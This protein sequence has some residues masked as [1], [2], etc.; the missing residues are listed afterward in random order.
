MKI[1]IMTFWWSEDNYGQILQCY[2]LQKYLRDTG[3]DAY[4]IRYDPRKDYIKNPLTARFLKALN[5]IKL[6]NFIRHKLR[7]Y[8][9]AKEQ[10]ACP[11]YFSQF[12]NRYLVQSEKIYTSYNQLKTDPPTADMYIVGSDQVWNFYTSKLQKVINTV[13]A[14]FLDF[15]GKNIKRVSYAASWGNFFI[16]KNFREEIQPLL[17][18]FDY[19]SV[20]EKSG[21]A[22]CEDCHAQA[23]WVP[24]PVFLLN[25]EAY[26]SLYMENSF[27]KPQK[28]YVFLYLLSNPCDC[29]IVD[30]KRWAESKGLDVVYVSGNNSID[31]HTKI[32]ASIPQ[33]LYLI[34]NAEYVITNS[35]HCCVVS[36]MF[37]KRYAAVPVKGLISGMN[38]RLDSLWE[39]LEVSPRLFINNNFSVLDVK[40]PELDRNKILS[41]IGNFNRILQMPEYNEP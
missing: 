4:L 34:D 25:T 23:D 41:K 5:P 37:H 15:G 8:R 9:A 16:E 19:V 6:Y 2:A 39:L 18:R 28:K 3:H 27:D 30:I 26:R 7:L 20:R 10:Q 33:W 12:R 38:S 31:G 24:D 21:I 11:R 1:G 40:Y 14:Y 22:I 17:E 35:F 29:S 32:F 36:S 13:H